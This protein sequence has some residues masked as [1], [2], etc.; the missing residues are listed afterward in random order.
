[1][2]EHNR[3]DEYTNRGGYRDEYG[4]EDRD[5]NGNGIGMIL[6]IGYQ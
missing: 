3:N 2:Y 5:G 4:E 1:M 6:Q